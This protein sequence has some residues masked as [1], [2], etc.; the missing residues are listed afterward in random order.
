MEMTS[1]LKINREPVRHATLQ[2]LAA[3]GFVTLIIAGIMLAIYAARFVPEA[4]SRVGSAAVYLSQVFTPAKKADLQVVTQIPF[5]VASTTESTT[6]AVVATT[7]TTVTKPV[8]YPPATTPGEET[9]TTYP[10]G[11]T[12]VATLHGLPDLKVTITQVGYLSLNNTDSFIAAK[13]IPSGLRGAVKFTVTNVGTN[14]T[15]NWSFNAN[16][17]TTSSF[18][19]NSDAQKPLLPGERIDYTLGFDRHS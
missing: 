13:V 5:G 18:T 8:T 17:P 10:S 11:G 7:T 9:T 15:G 1:T 16:L 3:V 12:P 6:T 19:F 2:G 14:T 4:A